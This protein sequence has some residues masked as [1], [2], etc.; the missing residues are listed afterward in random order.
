MRFVAKIFLVVV[1]ISIIGCR[2]LPNYFEGKD[3]GDNVVARVVRTKLYQRDLVSAVPLGIVGDD[4]VAFVDA[5]VDRWVKKQLKLSEAERFF[6]SLETD[7]ETLVEEYRQ[8]LFIRKLERHYVDNNIDT[9]FTKGDI[10]DYYQKNKNDFKLDRTIVKG[11]ILQLKSNYRQSK[12]LY[13]LMGS[14]TPA[15]D[16]EFRD[17]C[18]KNDFKLTEFKDEWIDFTEF[19]RYLPTLRSQTYDSVL[20][21]AKPQEMKDSYSLYYFQ[22]TEVLKVGEPRPIEHVRD[23]IRRI[24]FNRRQT[25]IIKRHEEN[26]Y[27]KALENN[28]IELYKNN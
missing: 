13:K 8:S 20:K 4:S 10:Y 12:S 17:I 14:S 7:I 19:L 22:I 2:E 9:T 21:T 16:Q 25:E 23:N 3:I 27:R 15:Q 24:L 1:L 18:A 5:Y 26:I 6:L 11:R 28:D